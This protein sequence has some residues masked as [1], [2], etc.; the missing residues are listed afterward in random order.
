MGIDVSDS[1]DEISWVNSY[2][3]GMKADPEEVLKELIYEQE[4]RGQKEGESLAKIGPPCVDREPDA[5]ETTEAETK[6]KK[7]KNKKKKDKNGKKVPATGA[8][9][10][11]IHDCGDK[12]SARPYVRLDEEPESEEVTRFIEYLNRTQIKP[13]RP[14]VPVSKKMLRGYEK[15]F[16]RL[17]TS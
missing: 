15:T 12:E 16:Q 5:A 17:L 9:E 4:K 11:S 8:E 14:V 1:D 6:K 13:D 2:L 7:K 10:I 3:Q